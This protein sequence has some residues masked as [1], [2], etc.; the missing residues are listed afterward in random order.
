MAQQFPFFDALMVSQFKASPL[1]TGDV[2]MDY[3]RAK[4]GSRRR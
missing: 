2:E 3:E 4:L 1:H